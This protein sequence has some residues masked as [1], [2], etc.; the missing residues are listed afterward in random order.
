M[1]LSSDYLIRPPRVRI[2]TMDAGQVHVNPN[3]V[4]VRQGLP[5]HSR[6]LVWATVEP[7]SENRVRSRVRTV[8][9]E[10]EAV[11]QNEPG[12]TK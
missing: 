11:Y 1:K 9:D 10:R 5:Q 6:H 7:G 2:M 12:I 4:V 3:L 8:A